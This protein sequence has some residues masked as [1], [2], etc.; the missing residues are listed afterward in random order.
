M[1][2]SRIKLAEM[3]KTRRQSIF[4]SYEIRANL[5]KMTKFSDLSTG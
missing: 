5:F 4:I 3:A 1:P 2:G